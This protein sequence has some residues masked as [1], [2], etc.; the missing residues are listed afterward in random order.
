MY[1]EAIT[2]IVMSSL[3]SVLMVSA[4]MSS[5]ILE[6]IVQVL[7]LNLYHLTKYALVFTSEN[8]L[9]YAYPVHLS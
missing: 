4:E 5:A 9:H 3:G 7:T 2:K 8:V 6:Y 1:V